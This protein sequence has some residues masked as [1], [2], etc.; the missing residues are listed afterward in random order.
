MC[1]YSELEPLIVTSHDKGPNRGIS[2]YFG[3]NEIDTLEKQ[4]VNF[5][6]NRRFLVRAT[7]DNKLVL[8]PFSE[9]DVLLDIEEQLD[10]I[11]EL[12]KEEK[13]EFGEDLLRIITK[14]TIE[15][16]ENERYS[17]FQ[18]AKGHYTRYNIRNA[19]R[20][21]LRADENATQDLINEY[22]QKK[23]R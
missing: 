9:I 11:T 1:E 6:N 18:F 23:E 15:I 8:I 20:V 16:T 7:K 21:G 19:I 10:K 2:I 5:R 13:E 14:D 3:I 12:G 22:I 4:G 17:V